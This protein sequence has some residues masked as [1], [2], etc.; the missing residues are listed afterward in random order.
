MTPSVAGFYKENFRHPRDSGI[1]CTCLG[2]SHVDAIQRNGMSI[3]SRA[4][5]IQLAPPATISRRSAPR[6]PPADIAGPSGNVL[7]RIIPSLEVAAQPQG[8]EL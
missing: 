6:P 7:V 1:R 2:K 3:I 8:K 5:E 4:F